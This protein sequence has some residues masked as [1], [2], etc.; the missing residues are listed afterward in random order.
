[1]W[2][3]ICGHGDYN[4]EEPRFATKLTGTHIPSITRHPIGRVGVI[5][6]ECILPGFAIDGCAK[7]EVNFNRIDMFTPDDSPLKTGFDL[8]ER[9]VNGEQL[10]FSVC[11]KEPAD[12]DYFYHQDE[13]IALQKAV[14]EDPY[15]V[16]PR[17]RT[18]TDCIAF[19]VHEVLKT[20]TKRQAN[21]A[22]LLTP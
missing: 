18:S 19:V 4:P 5:A 8:E 3:K 12:G 13:L 2:K 9:Y 14:E 11:T 22:W 7:V 20:R 21:S 10:L 1:M 17:R 6:A 16:P 15:V